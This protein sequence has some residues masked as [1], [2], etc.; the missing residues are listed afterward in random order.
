MDN[1][2]S[3]SFCSHYLDYLIQDVGSQDWGQ[4]ITL[5]ESLFYYY[6]FEISQKNFNLDLV[7]VLACVQLLIM[8]GY[9]KKPYAICRNVRRQS[10]RKKLVIK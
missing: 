7:P 1:F 2:N 3:R 8:Y 9:I 5:P 4:S 6:C 10:F